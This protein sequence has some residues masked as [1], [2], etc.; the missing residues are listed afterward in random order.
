MHSCIPCTGKVIIDSRLAT[1]TPSACK[2][3]TPLLTLVPDFVLAGVAG[4][5]NMVPA[6]D[7]TALSCGG[8]LD[9]TSERVDG[10]LE[11]LPCE[12]FGSFRLSLPIAPNGFML[13]RWRE[14]PVWRS[15]SR[16]L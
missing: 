3:N 1:E 7:V 13:P 15:S 14:P 6:T 4:C 2:F 12:R 5:L 10:V 8:P 11:C 9:R 16:G